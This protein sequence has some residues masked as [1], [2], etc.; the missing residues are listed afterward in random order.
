MQPGLIQ[1]LQ[2]VLGALEAHQ[3]AARLRAI[4]DFGSEHVPGVTGTRGQQNC[5]GSRERCD[6]D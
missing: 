2:K 5:G 1:G 3:D 6:M 4:A